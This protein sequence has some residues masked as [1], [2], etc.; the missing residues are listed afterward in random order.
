MPR[1][2]FSVSRHPLTSSCL[3]AVICMFLIP[4]GMQMLPGDTLFG[5]A[6][7]FLYV[8]APAW[9]ATAGVLSASDVRR[10]WSLPLVS[11]GIGLLG[12][13]TGFDWGNLDFVMFAFV[14]TAI[15]AGTMGLTL[16][17]RRRRRQPAEPDGGH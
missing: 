5:F 9:S 2:E 6:F 10:M 3:I 13:W 7:L 14:Y 8:V 15:G 1:K 12:C 4:V 16:L 17:L 11:A